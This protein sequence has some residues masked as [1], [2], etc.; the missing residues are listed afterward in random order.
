MIERLCASPL[1]DYVAGSVTAVAVAAGV[2]ALVDPSWDLVVA[3]LVGAAVGVAVHLVVL[4]AIGSLVGLFQ[5]M[6]PGSLI[7]M[8]GGM[9]FGMRDAMQLASWSQVVV[10]AALFGV[11]VVTL[12]QAYD[13]ALRAAGTQRR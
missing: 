10:V 3:I 9:L 6:V 2:H 11:V 1:G 13:R 8:Y 4:L 5:V 7:G 12:C